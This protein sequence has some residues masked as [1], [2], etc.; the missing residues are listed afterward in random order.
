MKFPK[1]DRVD[2]I[3]KKWLTAWDIEPF[4]SEACSVRGHVSINPRVMREYLFCKFM[5]KLC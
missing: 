1:V 2:L 5:R 4:G 3:G